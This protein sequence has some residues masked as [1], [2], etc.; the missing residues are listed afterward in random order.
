M[1]S[2][3]EVRGA[4]WAKYVCSIYI[5]LVGFLGKYRLNRE[6]LHLMQKEDKTHSQLSCWKDYFL[7]V[8]FGKKQVKN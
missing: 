3:V 4:I 5:L 2:Q 6:G 1:S 8:S 7:K